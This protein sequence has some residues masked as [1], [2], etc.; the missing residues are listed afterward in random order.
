MAK[1]NKAEFVAILDAVRPG[2]G[3]R[4]VIEQATSFAFLPGEVV[5]YNDEIAVRHPL[6]LQITGAVRANELYALVSKLKDDDIDIQITDNE[7]LISGKRAKA[8]IKIEAEIKL[9]LDELG[10][11]A[12]KFTAIPDTF[13][14]A[15]KMA[16][17]FAAK[18]MSKP[19]LTCCHIKGQLIEASDDFRI[20]RIDIGQAG[21]KAFKESLCIPA[22]A[23][24]SLVRYSVKEFCQTTGWAHFR[25]KNGVVFSCRT[26]ADEFPDIS[27]FLIVEG[28]ELKLPGSMKEVLDKAGVFSNAQIARDEEVKITVENKRMVI[29]GEGDYGWF[30]ESVNCAFSGDKIEFLVSPSMLADIL[31]HV[32]H[33]VVGENSMLFEGENFKHVICLIGE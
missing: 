17:N 1:I 11:L 31:D 26:Y 18:D 20:I 25:A 5:T 6:D 3:Q 4:D 12:D 14:P 10:T 16:M 15:L 32:T 21:K 9:P 7:L 27:P 22:T 8:G 13:L 2:L 28:V 23:A 19:I 24:K 30:E 29:R 33:C